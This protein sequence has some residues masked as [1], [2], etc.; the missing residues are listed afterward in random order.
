[1]KLND[2]KKFFVNKN[3]FEN[4]A[5]TV[6][7]PIESVDAIQKKTNTTQADEVKATEKRVISNFEKQ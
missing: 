4:P 1:M 5:V 7:R 3:L 2:E 6:S